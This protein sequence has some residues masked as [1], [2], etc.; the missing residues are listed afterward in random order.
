MREPRYDLLDRLREGMLI[1][2]GKISMDS[3]L[4]VEMRSYCSD[5]WGKLW[6]VTFI[7]SQSNTKMQQ[8][9]IKRHGGNEGDAWMLETDGWDEAWVDA[10][11]VFFVNNA[12]PRGHQ[13]GAGSPAVLPHLARCIDALSASDDSLSAAITETMHKRLVAIYTIAWNNLRQLGMV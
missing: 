9:T 13:Y 7:R 3:P 12:R 10:R 2:R 6:S 5:G 8:L 11:E 4:D 1:V